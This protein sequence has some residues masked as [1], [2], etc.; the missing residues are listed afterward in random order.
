MRS[1]GGDVRPPRSASTPADPDY[2]ALRE[3]HCAGLLLVGDRAYKFKKPVDFGFLDFSTAEKR[4]HACRREVEL[5]RRFSPD[6]YLGV[7]DLG[8]PDGRHEAVVV[9][10]RMPD[11]R[12]LATLVVEGAEVRDDLR[13]LAHQ[14]AAAHA[15]SPRADAIDTEA[16][17][18]RLR[19]RWDASFDQVLSL[20]PDVFDPPVVADVTR[21]THRFLGGREALFRQRIEA[22][23]A[24]DGHGDLMADDIFCL[25]D[26]PRALDCLEFDDRLRFVDRVDDAC[27]LAMDLERL[28]SPELGA[29]F[30][31][32]YAEFSGDPAPPS[33][34]HHYIA[35]RAFVRAKVAGL[36]AEQGAPT[37][38]EARLLAEQAQRHLQAGAVI[39]TLVGGAPGT[40][41]STVAGALADRLGMVV[42]SSDR[43]RKELAGLDPETS[44]A[45]PLH[46]GIY[47]TRHTDRTYAELLHRARLLLALG[48]S[49]VLDASWGSARHRAAA[50][51]VAHATSSDLREI[52]CVAPGDLAVRRVAARSATGRPVS[53]AD[54]SVATALAVERSPWPEAV[55]L[56]TRVEATESVDTAAGVVR[57]VRLEVPRRP[58][59]VMAP[60]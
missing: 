40:G 31:G 37:A 28:G 20:T 46:A 15:R 32:W 44:A 29:T 39:L 33:L 55:L 4:A 8:L 2:L 38:A 3:T 6:V 24:V 26:G 34:V 5:N 10:R 12:R 36:R 45:S 7:A 27:F 25:A 30:V 41:K 19:A 21:L 52:C 47:D 13:S 43:V 22:G 18:P 56:D 42:L 48:E 49:V 54:P 9:M 14:L 60:D 16:A 59:S 50:R 23:C 17:L 57:P 35:Y 51:S 58:R 1:A 11:D 53:D